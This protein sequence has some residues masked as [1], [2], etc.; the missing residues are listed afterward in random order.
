MSAL[1]RITLGSSQ[2][3]ETTMIKLLSSI[4]ST[5]IYF[6][7]NLGTV[8]AGKDD[9]RVVSDSRALERNPELAPRTSPSDAQSLRTC[10]PL[11]CH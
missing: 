5:G 4:I 1:P 8:V 9:E 11:T 3:T 10:R 6:A 7:G 2:V